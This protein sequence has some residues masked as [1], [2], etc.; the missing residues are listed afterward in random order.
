[1]ADHE[2]KAHNIYFTASF[3]ATQKLRLT[4]TVDYN[5]SEAAFESVEFDEAELR[6]RL[7]NDQHP[8][9]D[10][11]HFNYDFTPIVAYSDIDYEILR[12][13]F[14]AE[15][16]LAPRVTVT[17]DADYADLTDNAGSVYGNE[18]GSMMIVRGGVKLGL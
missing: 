15:Y 16:K 1:M 5:I 3:M 8:E 7:V 13:S 12:L 11:H 4:G 2:T 18:S 14:G 9:G 6:E 17:A 10:L